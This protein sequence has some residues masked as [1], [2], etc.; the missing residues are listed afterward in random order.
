MGSSQPGAKAWA[1]LVTRENYVPGLLALHRTLAAVS[2]YPLVVLVTPSLPD[3][4]RALITR[5]GMLVYNISPLAP[6]G[7]AGFDTKFERFADTW[8]KLQV[9]SVPGYDRLVLIDADTIFLRGMDELFT[10]E[11]PE[12]WIA[13]APACTCNPFKFAH[14]PKDWIPANCSFTHQPN[15][16]T[17]VNVPQP[18]PDAP[19]VAHLLNSGVVVLHP[20]PALM[21][22]LEEHLRTSPTV[23][24]AQFPDQEVLADVFRGRWRVLPWWTNA[25]KTLRAVHKPLWLDQEVRL[26]HYILEK[27]WSKL[28]VTPVAP[29]APAP[30]S[31]GDKLG[32]PPALCAMVASAAP[33]D[34]M[35][36]Y[37][38][39]HA[40]W[41]AVY[42]DVLRGL[43]AEE[44]DLWQE[45]D[46]WVAH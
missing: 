6:Q 33:Q 31:T 36:D 40:W 38:T 7:H 2:A 42:V 32:L 14:Y 12:D 9:F 29:Y 21:A 11:L 13:A 18:A 1:V 34:S 25:L 27:P 41:W 22:E 15:P 28:P 30:S 37:D 16:T 3:E 26:L 20:R 17:L 43:K 24:T 44:P 39:V 4:Y 23:A 5:R 45:V 10:M 46:K 35:T 19:R 8:T